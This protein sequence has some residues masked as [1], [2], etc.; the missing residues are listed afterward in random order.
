[1][2]KKLS[3][4]ARMKKEYEE[5]LELLHATQDRLA[6]IRLDYSRFTKPRQPK[7]TL[8]IKIEGGE[9]NL[10]ELAASINAANLLSNDVIVTVKDGAILFGFF[11]RLERKV[12]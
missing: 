3:A 6:E 5:A 4:G 11:E 1:M 9:V 7:A 2:A 10:T 8:G 12:Y